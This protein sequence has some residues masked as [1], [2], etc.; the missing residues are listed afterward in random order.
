MSKRRQGVTVAGRRPQARTRLAR[1]AV[2]RAAREEFLKCGYGTA[3]V[4]TI[5]ARADVPPATVYRLFSSKIGILKAVIDVSIA[6]DD[7]DLAVSERARIQS[8][9]EDPDPG[10]RIA[11]F[12]G[13]TADV[14]SRT[15]PLYQMLVSAAGSDPDAAALLHDLNHQRRQGQGLLAQSLA[16]AQTLRPPLRQRDA[17]DI[18]HTLMSPEVYRLLV[19]DSGWPPRRYQRWLTDTL[20]HQLLVPT[21]ASG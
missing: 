3:T 17:A 2:V 7:K 1:A 8:A 14:N 21:T 6:G 9:L 15:A 10:R 19:A 16:S 11:G 5:S 12:A 20:V 4:G 13:L 18:I